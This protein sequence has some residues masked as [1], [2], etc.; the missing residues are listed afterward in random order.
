MRKE[1]VTLDKFSSKGFKIKVVGNSWKVDGKL[2][3]RVWH[4]HD[5]LLAVRMF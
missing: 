4:R 5:L 1:L 3:E 2:V